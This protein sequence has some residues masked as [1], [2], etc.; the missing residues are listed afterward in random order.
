MSGKAIWWFNWKDD[1]R[2]LHWPHIIVSREHKY[3]SIGFVV[4][5]LEIHYDKIG[6]KK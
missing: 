2:Q 1:G 3:I 5:R 6:I 4:I